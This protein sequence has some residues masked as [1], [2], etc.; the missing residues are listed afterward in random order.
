MNNRTL[1]IYGDNNNYMTIEFKTEFKKEFTYFNQNDNYIF[2]FNWD[3]TDSQNQN[4]LI[5]SLYLEE[6]TQKLYDKLDSILEFKAYTIIGYINI[7]DTFFN[8]YY[9]YGGIREVGLMIDSDY[10]TGK[11][12]EF[13]MSLFDNI[14]E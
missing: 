11:S 6:K 5:N 7:I 9:A 13:F 8:K 1:S 10:H 3:N 2:R 4:N 12:Q 14:T